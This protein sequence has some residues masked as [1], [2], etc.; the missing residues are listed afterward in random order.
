MIASVSDLH[1]LCTIFFVFLHHFFFAPFLLF[2]FF[3]G[4]MAYSYDG[5]IEE[6][7]DHH[8]IS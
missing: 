4:I 5:C 8:S 7:G 1:H 3:I 2:L 6:S